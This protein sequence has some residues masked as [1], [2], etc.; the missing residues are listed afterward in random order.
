MKTPK[1]RPGISPSVMLGCC[2]LSVHHYSLSL[3]RA[4]PEW[5]QETAGPGLNN[6]IR[7]ISVARRSQNHISSVIKCSIT[8]YKSPATFCL[9]FSSFSSLDRVSVSWVFSWNKNKQSARL[10]Q[11][12][13]GGA[14]ENEFCIGQEDK[15]LSILGAVK[16]SI[17]AHPQRF[18]SASYLGHVETKNSAAAA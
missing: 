14:R 15:L 6:E 5:G 17:F 10:P 7:V 3:W 1:P 13:I 16:S 2:S 12:F 4:P 18:L 11:Q 9:S 8:L